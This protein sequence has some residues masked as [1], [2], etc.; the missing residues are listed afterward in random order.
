ML[1][2]PPRSGG[3]FFCLGIASTAA[4]GGRHPLAKYPH[5]GSEAVI[6]SMP[7]PSSSCGRSV[8][9]VV[10]FVV[11]T[12]VNGSR[13]PTVGDLWFALPEGTESTLDG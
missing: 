4:L 5:L 10:E 9:D 2:K 6:G 1:E 11:D 8:P 7:K 13:E 12:W 3:G